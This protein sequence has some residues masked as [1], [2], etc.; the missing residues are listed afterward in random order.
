MTDKELNL[1]LYHL[2]SFYNHYKHNKDSLLAKICGVFT[3]H[4]DRVDKVH[5]MLMEN[6]M[7]ISDVEQLRYIFD[8]KGSTVDRKV[9]GET[10]PTTTLKDLNYIQIANY[11]NKGNSKKR[12]VNFN[13][14]TKIKL[15]KALRSDVQFLCSLGLMDY[16]FLLAIETNPKKRM[17]S[18][19]EVEFL[20]LDDYCINE[21]GKGTRKLKDS[22]YF[23]QSSH[24]YHVALIDYL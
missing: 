5:I 23:E 20:Q 3:I 14:E 8:L 12:F 21:M 22:H 7:Q 24:I 9:K 6:T 19:E 11:R 10:K 2:Q 15:I 18:N 13:N 1:Y 16:S 4:S 17:L